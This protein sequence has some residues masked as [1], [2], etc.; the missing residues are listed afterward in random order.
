MLQMEDR[1]RQ[2]EWSV[3]WFIQQSQEDGYYFYPHFHIRN[4]CYK[5]ISNLSKN[6]SVLEAEKALEVIWIKFCV[7]ADVSKMT[8]QLSLHTS[9]REG[10]N[11]IDRRFFLVFSLPK[12]SSL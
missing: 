2:K 10:K 6:H 3:S 5:T 7:N 1:L 12:S 9:T 11:H 4:W 8:I